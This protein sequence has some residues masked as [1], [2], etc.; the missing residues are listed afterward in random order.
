MIAEI[1]DLSG[2]GILDIQGLMHFYD[3]VRI[4]V[5]VSQELNID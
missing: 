2:E 5:G 3:C 1:A 4:E